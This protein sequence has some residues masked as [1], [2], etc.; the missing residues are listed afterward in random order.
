MTKLSCKQIHRFFIIR[1]KKS[2]KLGK[3]EK[4]VKQLGK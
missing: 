2:M 1:G 3:G 4:K